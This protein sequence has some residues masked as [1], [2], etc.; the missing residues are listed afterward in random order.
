MKSQTLATKFRGDI[1]SKFEEDYHKASRRNWIQIVCN[2]GVA[3]QLTVF[4]LIEA[5]PAAELPLDFQ[6]SFTSSCLIVAILGRLL[7]CVNLYY[8]DN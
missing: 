2:L 5:G 6:K 1:K 7:V 3:A 4:L 8:N